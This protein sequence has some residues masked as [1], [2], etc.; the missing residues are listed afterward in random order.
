[1][2]PDAPDSGSI[3]RAPQ[4]DSCGCA[5]SARFLGAALVVAML[6]YGWSWLLAEISLW[7]VLWRVIVASFVAAA[8]GKILGMALYARSNN[9]R[10]QQGIG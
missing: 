7:G 2:R 3:R 4:G 1:M 5:M 10:R 8:L 9:R 6:W